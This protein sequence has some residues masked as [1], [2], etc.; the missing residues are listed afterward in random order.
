M[1]GLVTILNLLEV[2]IHSAFYK[3]VSVLY[4]L[5]V[6]IRPDYMNVRTRDTAVK[7]FRVTGIYPVYR[8]I[9]VNEILTAAGAAVYTRDI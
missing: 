2:K 6:A 1:R 7:L 8:G 9:S 4:D 3:S 5:V